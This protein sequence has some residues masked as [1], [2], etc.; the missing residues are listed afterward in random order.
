MPYPVHSFCS[1]KEHS[2]CVT[3]LPWLSEGRRG[4]TEHIPVL[5]AM[6][7]EIFIVLKLK[8]INQALQ[9]L[10]FTCACRT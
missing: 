8:Y 6:G 4:R 3:W 5:E 10:L 2:A 7:R 9:V 1:A